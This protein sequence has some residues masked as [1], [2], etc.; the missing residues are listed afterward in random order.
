M[1]FNGERSGVYS[2]GSGG[3][4][5]SA[6]QGGKGGLGV[7]RPKAQ[8]LVQDPDSQPEPDGGSGGKKQKA[9]TALGGKRPK[10]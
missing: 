10:K 9:S 7:K 6:N 2:S 3:D 5:G 1:I 4:G 8:A